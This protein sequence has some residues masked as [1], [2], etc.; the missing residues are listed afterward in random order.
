MGEGAVVGEEH[1]AHRVL[2]QPPGGE[3]PL[4]PQL[5]RHQV[6]D[7]GLAAVLGGGDHPGGFVQHQVDVLLKAQ[8]H[9]VHRHGLQ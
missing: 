5:R 6:E 8:R 2:V 9:P 4:A 3:E 1:K 7:G